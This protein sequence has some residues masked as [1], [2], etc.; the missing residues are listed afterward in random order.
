MIVD[1]TK[2]KDLT[3]ARFEKLFVEARAENRGGNVAWH[4]LCDCGNRCIRAS[5][6]LQIGASKSCGCNKK[7]KNAGH[8]KRTHGSLSGPHAREYGIWGALKQR[9]GNPK[10]HAYERYGGAGIK[11]H[12]QWVDSFESFLAHIGPAPSGRHSIDR[13]DGSLGYVPGNIRWATPETQ[14]TN[15]RNVRLVAINGVEKPLPDWCREYGANNKRCYMRIF[16][17]GWEPLR[18]LTTP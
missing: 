4:C 9:T 7:E 14:N 13:I 5:T 15:R 18:A 1:M 8:F 2:L 11:L 12:P 10:A 3:G 17:C 16:V 6:T